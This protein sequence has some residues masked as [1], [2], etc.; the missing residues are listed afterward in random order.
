MNGKPII[1]FIGLRAKMY[2]ILSEEG[3][4]KTAKGV[5]RAV[6]KHKIKHRHYKECLEG[7]SVMREKQYRI[8][9]VDHQLHTVVNNKITLSAFDDKRYLLEDGIHSY[10]YGHYQIS[11]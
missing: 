11:Q 7:T 9:S 4:K 6:L 1:E 10:A 3:E 8:Q 5:A 2:S